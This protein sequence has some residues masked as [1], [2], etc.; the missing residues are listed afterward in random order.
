MG[1]EELRVKSEK[2]EC[3]MRGVWVVCASCPYTLV[4]G[5]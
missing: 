2:F 1:S 5:K 4:G 3:L